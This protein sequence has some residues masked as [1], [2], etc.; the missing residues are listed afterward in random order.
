MNKIEL[1]R[2]LVSVRVKQAEAHGLLVEFLETKL[3]NCD[4]ANRS[5][6]GEQL[7][8]SQGKA[9]LLDE[10]VRLIDTPNDELQELLANPEV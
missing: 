7:Y 8:R 1:L 4:K 6:T 10:L 9:Q 5:L 2:G 3:T